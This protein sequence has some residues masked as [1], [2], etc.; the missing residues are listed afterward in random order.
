[1][2]LTSFKYG[3]FPVKYETFIYTEE[4]DIREGY[5]G[6][7]WNL[8]RIDF[9]VS[10]VHRRRGRCVLGSSVRSRFFFF[11]KFSKR[12]NFFSYAFCN[13][14]HRV[15]MELDLLPGEGKE[16]RKRKCK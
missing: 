7:K 4:L 13:I 2:R 5:T 11:L 10:G 3:N 1:M 12:K 15:L 9:W 16:N 8:F 6:G 14:F